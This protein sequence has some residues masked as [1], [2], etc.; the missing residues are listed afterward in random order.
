[1]T[2]TT[3]YQTLLLAGDRIRVLIGPGGLF[4]VAAVTVGAAGYVEA[5][6]NYW[7]TE[8]NEIYFATKEN[9]TDRALELQRKGAQLRQLV[10]G[11]GRN[12][13]AAFKAAMNVRGLPGG[14]PRPPL[15]PLSE[16]HLAELRQGFERLGL[17]VAEAAA[18]E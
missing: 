2:S 16:S 15:R 10:E 6:Q 1:M 3:F 5:N 7:G 17:S 8:A 4:G 9:D 12:I 18:A 14:Y 11:G 13:Y